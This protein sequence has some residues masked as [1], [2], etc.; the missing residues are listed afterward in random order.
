M[1]GSLDFVL[2]L[3]VLGLALDFE[4]NTELSAIPELTI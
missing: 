4:R 3:W 2:G 1:V